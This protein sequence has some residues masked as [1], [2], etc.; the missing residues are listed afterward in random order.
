MAKIVLSDVASGYN[1]QRINENFQA[2]EDEL[3]NKVLYRDNPAGQPNVMVNDIDMNS[4]DV[5]NA[6]TVAVQAITLA[7]VNYSTVLDGK[8]TE[9]SGFADASETSSVSS[10]GYASNSSASASAS[11]SSASASATS[12]GESASSASDSSAS[13]VSS[14][15]SAVLAATSAANGTG[16]KTSYVSTV[17][18]GGTTFDQPAVLG[19]ISSDQ[20]YF[21]IEYAG[22]TGITVANLASAS[23]YVYIDNTGALQQQTTAP[24]RQDWSRKMF[25]MRIAVASSV[26]VGFEYLNNP[27]GHYANS[28]R[29]LYTYLLAQGVPFKKDQLVTGRA[30]DLGFDISSGTLLEFGGTG[31]INNANVKGFDAVANAEF[32]LVER[33]SFDAGGNTDLP[34]FWDNN[35]TITALG[36][37]TVVGHRLYRFSNGNVCLQYGQGN[38][39]NMTLAKS[40]ALL[41][42]FVLNPILANATFFGWWFIESTAT[43]TGGTTLTDFKEY[44]IGMQ[45]GSSSGLSGAV[46]KGN[47]GSDFLDYD[48]LRS[49]IGV[50]ASG[51]V[52]TGTTAQRPAVPAAGMFRYNESLAQFEGYGVGWAGVGGGGPSLGASSVIRTNAKVISQN[53][54][55]AG[56]ENGSSVGPI[57]IDTGYTVTV[58][59][60]STWVIL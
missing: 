4:Y 44:T 23:T 28:I 11:A 27:I 20:G 52:P 12:A 37:T 59:T 47:N 53:I 22:A 57:T 32:F 21:V 38:Y 50:D 25:T 10:A 34:K 29:D 35:G 16:V 5:L 45:G 19:E 39:A 46:L 18:V 14:A 40:G 56:T 43:N 6:G 36:S 1:R 58:T 60:G 41:E 55:F 9:A 49:N 31:D 15:E 51:T 33:T 17:V 54:T 48:A 42:N 30:A 13:A 7:G 2:L 26:I 8:V 24:T 3:N